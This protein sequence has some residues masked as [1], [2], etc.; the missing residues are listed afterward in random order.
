MGGYLAAAATLEVAVGLGEVWQNGVF[1]CCA[2]SLEKALGIAELLNRLEAEGEAENLAESLAKA[3]Q[4]SDML[5]AKL[6]IDRALFDA[7]HLRED[8]VPEDGWGSRGP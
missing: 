7:P 6:G 8:T 4:Q 1:I 3:K 5:L 2:P